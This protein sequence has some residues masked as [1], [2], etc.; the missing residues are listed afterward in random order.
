MGLSRGY[1]F[2]PI[3]DRFIGGFAPEYSSPYPTL[4]LQGL[5]IFEGRPFEAQQTYHVWRFLLSLSKW[6][7]IRHQ[8]RTGCHS[9]SVDVLKTAP[10]GSLNSLEND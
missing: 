10:L 8:S 1:S 3:M 5:I 2:M 4:R 6:L 9:T 7:A